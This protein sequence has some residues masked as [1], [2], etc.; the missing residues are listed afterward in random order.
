ME[1]PACDAVTDDFETNGVTSLN[2]KFNAVRQLR[3]KTMNNTC[4]LKTDN[5]EFSVSLQRYYKHFHEIN[6]KINE[7]VLNV[8]LCSL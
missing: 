8:N 5:N 7:E 1:H 6:D 2:R 4:E 3:S